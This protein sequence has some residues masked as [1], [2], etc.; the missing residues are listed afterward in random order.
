MQ[1]M[2]CRKEV[3]MKI[4]WK[5][6]YIKWGLTALLVI[7]GSIMFYYLLFHSSNIKSAF[8]VIVG[9]MMPVV[10]GFILAYLLTPVLNIIEQK[11]MYPLRKAL[12]LKE[13]PKTHKRIR[14]LSILITTL[15]FY[16]V[17][18]LLVSMLVSQ[19][20]PSIQ[21]IVSNFDTYKTNFTTWM[22]QLL[23]DNPDIKDY[24]IN[25]IN[26]YSVE[27]EQFLNETVLTKS[28]ELIKTVSLSV[29]GIF[30]TLWNFIIGFIISIYILGSKE[31]FAIQ[32]KKLVYACY[33]ADTANVIINN[34][35]FAHNTFI[36]FI[37]GK[38]L[39]SL[40]IGMLCFIGTTLMQTPYAALISVIIGVT[41][42]IPFFGPFL[43][44]IPSTI[45]I[46]VVDPM[47]PLH[48]VYFI[49]FILI[50]QQVDGNLIGPK[51]LGDSTGLSGFW[52]IFAITLFGG[53][54]D[55]LGMIVGVPIFAIIY[56]AVR[57][58]VNSALIKKNMPIK[59]GVYEN[60]ECV[61][62]AGIHTMDYLE[63][64]R[65]IKARNLEKKEKKHDNNH[66]EHDKE[67]VSGMR[68]ISNVEEWKRRV[69]VRWNDANA[70]ARTAFE[71]VPET[72]SSAP[73]ADS[74][75][76]ENAPEIDSQ[77]AAGEEQ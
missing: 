28:S 48:C 52:V 30:K 54:F 12:K 1:A 56:A 31:K 24:A 55:V 23:A 42:I 37:S 67:L 62:E 72:E 5:N 68:F 40:I 21:N 6:Q 60:I 61:D 64:R 25:L 32:A 15:L 11:I 13:G 18:H 14:M 76:K 63:R 39:D 10:F 73:M 74:A 33:H 44:A 3:T 71:H 38:I 59:S 69:P 75:P 45:L 9:I 29:L 51:I 53:L 4:R 19:I 58:H 46:L 34:F 65:V 7:M 36:G 47:H 27:L 8:N 2:A 70:V 22:N 35:R 26:R 43:G 66:E 49:I 57:S 77:Q 41:N 20:V 17:I 16:L 50:L